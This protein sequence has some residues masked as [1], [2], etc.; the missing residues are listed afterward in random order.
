MIDPEFDFHF[1]LKDKYQDAVLK[2][3]ERCIRTERFKLVSTPGVKGPIYRLYDVLNDKHCQEDV[4]DNYPPVFAAMK[5]AL[6]RWSDQ[7]QQ[8][9]IHDIFA[10]QDEMK[11]T[12][13]GR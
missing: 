1:V 9:K 3:K 8:T 2:T 4:K 5:A 10:G 7:H 6:Y 11:F 13:T 12:A